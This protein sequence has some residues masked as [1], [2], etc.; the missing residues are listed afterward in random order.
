MPPTR[1]GRLPRAAGAGSHR[2]PSNR[3]PWT[4]TFW[5]VAALAAVALVTV[6]LLRPGLGTETETATETGTATTDSPGA[7]HTWAGLLSW[8]EAELPARTLVVVPGD[9][10][11]PIV[12]A[13]G[14]EDRFLPSGADAP[15]TLLLVEGQPPQGAVPIAR[16]EDATGTAFTVVDPEPGEPTSEELERRERLSAAI[17]AN[18]RTGATGRA[19]DVLRTA[20]VDARLLGLLAALVAQ[21]GVGVADFPPDPGKPV[22]GPPARRVLLD[23]LGGEPLEP[24]APATD[25][26]LIFLAAQLPPFAPDTVEVTDG[27]VLVGFRYESAPDAVV[28]ENTP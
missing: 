17:L 21:L 15:G 3:S 22:D 11:G 8:T 14:D 13:G 18:P 23:R 2:A 28:T 24:G 16:F 25:R 10:R 26:L 9:L 20:D 12:A 6:F 5:S 7:R 4:T 1:P 19:A 27:G